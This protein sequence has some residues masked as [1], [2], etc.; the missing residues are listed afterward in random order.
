MKTRAKS[1]HSLADLYN[2]RQAVGA[3]INLKGYPG[4]EM[5]PGG[6]E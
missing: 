4:A 1:T 6:M 5:P 3:D 2:S